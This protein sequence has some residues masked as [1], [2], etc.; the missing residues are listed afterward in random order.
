MTN[1]QLRISSRARQALVARTHPLTV[2]LELYFS[3]LIRKRVIF[4]EQA[5]TDTLAVECDDP[6]LSVHFLPVMSTVCKV[7][8]NQDGPPLSR[9]PIH[10][11]QAF[12]P[13]WLRIDYRGGD[14]LGEF[15]FD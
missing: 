14:W 8:D 15:G 2:V 7:S 6:N 10:H 9:F 12:V 1:L 5:G 13:K 4:P 3:C 11:P